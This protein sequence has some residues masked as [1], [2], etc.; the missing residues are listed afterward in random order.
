MQIFVFLLYQHQTLKRTGSGDAEIAAA[1]II[2]I[3]VSAFFLV[4]IFSN[5]LDH[6]TTFGNLAKQ[7]LTSSDDNINEKNVM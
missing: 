4:L 7:N 5:A 1:A 3:M 2:I 6:N